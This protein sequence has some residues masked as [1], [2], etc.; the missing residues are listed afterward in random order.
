[1]TSSLDITSVF[2]RA[3]QLYRRHW[4]VLLLLS[5]F[6]FALPVAMLALVAFGALPALFALVAASLYVNGAFWYQG[7]ATHLV[8]QAS[9]AGDIPPVVR[10]IR[11]SLRR[12]PVVLGAGILVVL[13]VFFGLLLLV[14]PGLIFLAWWAVAIPAA[15]AEGLRPLAALGRSR[16]LVRETK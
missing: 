14:V 3:W 4:G 1:M 15:V 13:G 9:E 10:L 5:L 6:V 2:R 12:L 7:L 16:R 11:T 8:E